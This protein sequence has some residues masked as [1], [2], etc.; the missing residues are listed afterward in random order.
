MFS[1]TKIYLKLLLKNYWDNINNAEIIT[2]PQHNLYF[3]LMT[4]YLLSLSSL[5]TKTS[6]QGYCCFITSKHNH[7]YL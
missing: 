2:N 6:Y 1:L 3:E 5:T 4:L 7:I